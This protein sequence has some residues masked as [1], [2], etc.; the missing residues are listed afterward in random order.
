MI[1][2][3]EEVHWFSSVIQIFRFSNLGQKSAISV[4][5]YGN[6]VHCSIIIFFKLLEGYKQ[7]DSLANFVGAGSTKP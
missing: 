2:F 3:A 4:K 7:I 5:G 6:I 1:Q